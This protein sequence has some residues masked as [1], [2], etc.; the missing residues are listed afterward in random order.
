LSW[1]GS[2]YPYLY[3]K[4]LQYRHLPGHYSFPYANEM[5]RSPYNPLH[6]APGQ[7][8]ISAT[9]LQMGVAEGDIFEAFRA[10][11]PVARI[12]RSVFVYEVT[13]PQTAANPTCISGFKIEDL[14]SAIRAQS[15][16]RGPGTIK[17][18][19]YTMGFVLPT[20]G[21]TT[22]VLPSPPLGFAPD[23]QTLFLARAQTV[24]TQSTTDEHAAATVYRL[25][26]TSA[27][28]LEK[29]FSTTR[30]A[31]LAWSAATHFVG[32]FTKSEISAPVVFD[33]GIELLGYRLLSDVELSPQGA[34]SLVTVWHI[35]ADMP[36]QSGDLKLFI[37]LLD[38]QGQMRGGQDRL[39]SE[40]LTWEP[41]D[42][43]IQTHRVQIPADA[44]PGTYQVEL[45]LYLPDTMQRLAVHD[46]HARVAD[47]LL[48]HPMQ[49]SNP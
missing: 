14:G 6:P 10:T 49:V 19:D 25:G 37:H 17:W 42:L 11:E 13:D 28:E 22:Y 41:G 29:A 48:F 43:V 4:D 24:Y 32:E 30:S 34:L 12:G 3:D 35:T 26:S 38:A 31:P 2:T 18:F 23:W 8:A 21:E 44:S 15:L 33:L 16:Q 45:G 5:A 36:P 39:D 40:P 27:S 1:F 46:G 20:T 9:N 7:Y 47:R